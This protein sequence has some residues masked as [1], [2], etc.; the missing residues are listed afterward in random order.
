MAFELFAT[1]TTRPTAIFCDTSFLVDLLTHELASVGPFI[2]LNP[3]K[4]ARAAAA[5]TFFHQYTAN[6]TRFFSSP[7]VF[8]ELA[9]ILGRGVL[10]S[11]PTKPKYDLWPDLRNK[12]AARFATQ[13]ALWLSVVSDS[14][15]RF[16]Q[17]GIQFTV[18]ESTPTG[19]GGDVNVIVVEAARLLKIAHAELDYA[20]TFHIAMGVASGLSWF[21]TVDGFWKGI[22]G[23]NVFCDV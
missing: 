13:H 23:I 16:Q 12:D 11:D 19:Y 1:A 15:T 17:Y 7:Y 3:N 18:P 4:V 10:R 8:Q 14:W 2:K 20:D 6:G 21:A 22:T 9:Y 5:A